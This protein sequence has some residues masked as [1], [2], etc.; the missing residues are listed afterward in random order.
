EGFDE[1][2]NEKTVRYFRK[3]DAKGPNYIRDVKVK[4]QNS[5]TNKQKRKG[6]NDSNANK[7][8]KPKG[9]H[10]SNANKK[11]KTY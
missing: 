3:R 9:K 11:L 2:K 8:H 6:K 5:D 7:T 4:Q 1:I 10:D